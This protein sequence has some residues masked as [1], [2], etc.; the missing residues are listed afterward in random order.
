MTTTLS[1][2]RSFEVDFDPD[3][4]D[5]LLRF[6]RGDRFAIGLCTA[7]LSERPDSILE[8]QEEFERDYDGAIESLLERALRMLLSDS[9]PAL[10]AA[11]ILLSQCDEPFSETTLDGIWKKMP[12]DESYP[13]SVLP[14]LASLKRIEFVEPK[15]DG[16]A[17]NERV[18]AR[19]LRRLSDAD[20]QSACVT[21]ANYFAQSSLPDHEKI[22]K[23]HH[24]LKKAGL[25]KEAAQMAIAYSTAFVKEG[26]FDAARELVASE[27]ADSERFEREL[28]VFFLHQ[29]SVID[30]RLRRFE[31]AI[32]SL[33]IVVKE[34]AETDN[35]AGKLAAQSQLANLYAMTGDL[36]KAKT[37]F[38][39]VL[40]EQER[41]RNL[42]GV[43]A[44]SAQIGMIAFQ[45]RNFPLAVEKFHVACLLSERLTSEERRLYRLNWDYLK[46]EL[47]EARLNEWLALVK[48]QSESYVNRLLRA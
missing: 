44:A 22:P 28:R 12:W 11:C 27:L 42:S 7:Y 23:A 16:L 45:E 30:F 4:K 41:H 33:E 8:L 20:K 32:A 38:E 29:L 2:L 14:V 34:L 43:A 17:L 6:A 37:E 19:V 24:Y 35:V 26:K 1:A 40:R 9:P 3:A 47:G 48:E 31:D 25:A 10:Y 13:A 21:I 18:K 15:G 46:D 39:L 5:L 36:N